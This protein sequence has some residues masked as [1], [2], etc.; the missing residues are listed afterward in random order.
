[1]LKDKDKKAA[2]FANLRQY[3]NYLMKGLRPEDFGYNPLLS[4]SHADNAAPVKRYNEYREQLKGAVYKRMTEESGNKDRVDDL[5]GRQYFLSSEPV[6]YILN[7][8]PRSAAAFTEGL[9][10][11]HEG[12]NK[13]AAEKFR[14]K[15]L[16][17]NGEENCYL[18]K[19]SGRVIVS[20]RYN[21]GSEFVALCPHLYESVMESAN[22]NKRFEHKG[23]E[24]FITEDSNKA[25]LKAMK[26]YAAN[27]E[28]VLNSGE[29]LLLIGPV[30]TGKTHLGMAVLTELIMRPLYLRF[31]LLRKKYISLPQ[32][33]TDLRASGDENAL[34]DTAESEFLVVDDMGIETLDDWAREKVFTLVNTRYQDKLPTLFISDLSPS[35]LVNKLD[36]RILSRLHEMCRGVKIGGADRRLNS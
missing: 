30:G 2:D 29:S 1:M 33:L 9:K 3:Y 16:V 20:E 4:H 23:F 14:L 21:G 11:F 26:K 18:C 27:F 35:E 8:K 22:I 32:F 15:P 31:N 10:K 12:V 5:F 17:I 34:K 25:A 36:E 28:T 19:R 6:K 7:E 24:D 13:V